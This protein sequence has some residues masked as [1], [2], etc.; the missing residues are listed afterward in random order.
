MTK[1]PLCIFQPCVVK[2]RRLHGIPSAHSNG[3]ASRSAKTT[4]D[5]SL[6]N[7]TRAVGLAGITAIRKRELAVPVTGIIPYQPTLT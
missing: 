3:F 7:K 6:I 1:S 2:K 4:G 5:R